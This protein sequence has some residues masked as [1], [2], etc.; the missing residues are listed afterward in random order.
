MGYRKQNK[1]STSR[2][3][4]MTGKIARVESKLNLQLSTAAV[5]FEGNDIIKKTQRY[6]GQA[7]KELTDDVGTLHKLNDINSQSLLALMATSSDLADAL[8]NEIR[9]NKEL[10]KWLEGYLIA[11]FAIVV[12][13]IIAVFVS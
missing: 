11:L 6:H 4:A 7:V 12:C 8:E 13:F 10:R 1:V 9:R 3:R 5:I 2:F